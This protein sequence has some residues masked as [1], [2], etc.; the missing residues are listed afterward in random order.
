MG[1]EGVIVCPVKA[2]PANVDIP[3]NNRET[4]KLIY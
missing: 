2:Y 3:P 4:V 1:M